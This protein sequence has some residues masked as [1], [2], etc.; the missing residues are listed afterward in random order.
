M[1]RPA[2]QAE[3]GRGL[4]LIRE[5]ADHVHIG[6][7]PGRAGAVVSFDKVLK[8]RENAPLVAV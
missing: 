4:C 5:L 6:S 1:V 8:W 2:P 3:S 7:T